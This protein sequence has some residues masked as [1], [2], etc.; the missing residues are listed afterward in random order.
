MNEQLA[1]QL[2]HCKTLPT[3]P[4]IAVKVIELAND[5][6]INLDDLCK[7]IML[8]PA[9]S[10]KIL[11]MANSPLY[12]SRRSASNIRQAISILGTHTIIVIALSFSLTNTFIRN[13]IKGNGIIDNTQFWRRAIA[14]ALACRT[15]GEKL[16]L[17]FV[18]DLFLAGLL[19][20]IG[21]LAYI[22]IMPDEYEPVYTS[23]NDHDA[24][25]MNERLTFSSGHDEVGYALL[26][27]WHIPDHIALTC[28]ASHCQPEPQ[29][30]SS[31]NL[32][33]C[34]AVSRYLAEY[35]LTPSRPENLINLIRS[36]RAWLDIDSETLLEVFNAMIEALDSIGDLFEITFYTPA[37]IAGILDEAKELLALQT[38]TKVKELEEKT[39]H[40]G[41]TGAM[42]RKF[43][44]ETI[45]REFHLSSQ[46]QFPLTIVMIDI[47]H[48]KKINDTYG[49]VA[50]DE[51]L[52]SFSGIIVKQIREED[53]FCRYGGEEF[54]LILPGTPPDA[55]RNIT[56]RLKDAITAHSIKTDDGTEIRITASF[57]VAS[58]LNG[59][60]CFKNPI[61]L[62]KAADSAL[63][64]AKKAGRN[65][66][67]E[68]KQS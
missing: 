55:A 31:P 62:I 7:Y 12:K 39:Q 48:F 40:D 56:R 27:Q 43:F 52:T 38:V 64:E 18:D 59:I 19:Q 13:P 53:S 1:N 35:F 36:A 44:D 16:G 37:E 15:L 54:A 45:Q 5:P 29:M 2:R 66:I 11:K 21:I 25:L 23:S 41:L 65:C 9:L 67:V 47:D 10:A 30:A 32:Y 34:A 28:I 63:L 3:L 20:D 8:D 24:L 60:P 4:A 50:G 49:H 22:A 17:R 51:I 14:S 68:W 61:D 42:N 26:K 6:D 33:S 58:C 46:H 57:G